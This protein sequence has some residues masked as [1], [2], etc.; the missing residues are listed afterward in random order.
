MT[1]KTCARKEESYMKIAVIGAG[2]VGLS[3]AVML[4]K[5]NRVEIVDILPEK[6]DAVNKKKFP[7]PGSAY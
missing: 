5:K 2:Y 6:V 1:A 7:Y 3:V 4:A